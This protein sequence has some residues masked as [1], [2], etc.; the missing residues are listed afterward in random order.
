[1]S[2]IDA[3]IAQARRSG[4]FTERRR[5]TLARTQ[6]I[7]KLRQF[8]LADPA[9]YILELIQSAIANGATWIEIHRDDDTVTLGYIGG[10]IPEAALGRLFDFLFASKDRADLGYLRELAIGVNALMVYQPRKIII[11]SGDGTRQGT[12]RMELFAGEDRLDVG[13]PDHALAGTFIRAEGLKGGG[14]LRAHREREMIETRC[15]AAPVPIL[16]NSEPLF[17]HSTRR[18]PGIIGFRQHMSFDEGDLYGTIGLR[19]QIGGK[20]EFNLLTRGVLIESVEHELVPGAPLGGVVCCDGLRKSA[21]H[22]RIVRDDRFAELWLRLRPYAR[23]LLGRQDAAPILTAKVHGGEILDTVPALRAWLRAALRVVIIP[24]LLGEHAEA[25]ARAIAEAVGGQLLHAEHHQVAALRLLA[26][27]VELHTP[28]LG[29]HSPD[30]AFY[31]QPLAQAPARPWLVQPIELPAVAV[32]DLRPGPIAELLGDAAE[33]RLK[34]YTPAASEHAD[35]ALV[36]FHSAGRELARVARPA[37]HTGHV[38]VVTLPIVAPSQVTGAGPEGSALE[39][40]ADACLR[41]AAASLADAADRVLAG[42]VDPDAALGPVERQRALL[43]VV[44][45]AV[46]RLRQGPP[47]LAFSLVEPGPPGVDLLGLR[48]FH[49][50]DGARL[51]CRELAARMTRDAGRLRVVTPAA[52]AATSCDALIVDAADLPRLR[53]LVGDAIDVADRTCPE[54]H[55]PA[56]MDRAGRSYPLA[57]L[58]AA[59]HAGRRLI[60]HPARTLPPLRPDADADADAIPEELWIAP[61]AYLALAG[62]GPLLPAAD[63][64]LADPEAREHGDELAFVAVS[65]ITTHEVQGSIGVPLRAPAL[66]GVVV[67]DE[68]LRPL[69]RFD[70]L[71]ADFGV[72]G[73]LR[74]RAPWSDPTFVAITAAVQQATAAL[75]DDLLARIPAMDPHGPVFARAAATVLAH[76]GRRVTVVADPHGHLRVPPVGAVAERVLGLPLFPGRRGLPLAAWQLVRRFVAGGGDPRAAHAELDLDAV[77]AVLR[78]WIDHTLDPDR[79]AREPAAGIVRQDDPGV[80]EL[81]A[82]GQVEAIA[83]PDPRA[84]IDDVSLAATLEYWLHQLRPDL[85]ALRPWDRRGRVWIE[86]E[87]QPDCDDFAEVTGDHGMWSVALRQDHWLLRWAAAAGRRD[88]EPIAWLLLA[89]YARIN[90]VFA[91][92]TN[93]HEGSMQRAVADALEH[94]RLAIV[95]PRF[96]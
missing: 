31:A 33:L 44:R 71:A 78:A 74:L 47:G 46:L 81:D 18:I 4:G 50:A 20:A 64:H 80:L 6:A 35:A 73:L 82:H 86:L 15:L 28:S 13:R 12:T 30:P 57:A 14:K 5:F 17:G 93:H 90:E 65:A 36:V 43:A 11:E 32:A 1:M 52:A 39:L 61:W 45:S 89:C 21:D 70:D 67:V 34:I 29:P 38:L 88:R 59:L 40:L 55:V 25:A 42:L 26:G 96:V 72:V 79:V 23:A 7:Q 91:E 2:S 48:L 77:P 49:T 87:R 24:A 9:G 41:H 3:V 60:V 63:F 8:A 84:A 85:P 69:Y 27:G 83:D 68:Q 53:A 19:A 62:A 92:V 54:E 75:Y 94:G 95:V 22:A 16:Y 58:A 51:S 10:G 66:F 56:A 37:L 76:A